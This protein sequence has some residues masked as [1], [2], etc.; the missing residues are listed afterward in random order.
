M[1][2]GQEMEIGHNNFQEVE[3]EEDGK[4]AIKVDG[5]TEVNGKNIYFQERE[6]MRAGRSL[7]FTKIE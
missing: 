1:D 7:G 5:N 3:K 4:D 2:I 6:H